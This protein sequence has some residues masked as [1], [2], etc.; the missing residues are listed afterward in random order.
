IVVNGQN[1][2]DAGV[3]YR[4]TRSFQPGGSRNGLDIL[5][6]HVDANTN[7]QGYSS[8]KLSSALRDPSM[9]RE[10]LGYEIARQYMPA[11]KAN[12]ARV[13]INGKLYGLFV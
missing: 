6:N 7:Y 8:I 13:T 2:E 1:I 12:Y 3:R 9:V 5:L 10:V 4:A 11:P